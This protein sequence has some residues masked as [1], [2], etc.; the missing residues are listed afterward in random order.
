MNLIFLNKNIILP[1]GR[2]SVW[3]FIYAKKVC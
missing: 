1:R 3:L 2:S